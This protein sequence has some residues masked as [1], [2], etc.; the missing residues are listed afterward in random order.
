MTE[1]AISEAVLAH[2]EALALAAEQIVRWNFEVFDLDLGVTAAQDVRERS[3]ERHR[4]NVALDAISRV[5][6]FDEEGRELLVARRVRI[7]LGH[8]EGNIG[9]AC[10][11]RKPFLA[12]QD[13][14]VV[15]G[16]LGARLHARGVRAGR[17]L[18]HRIADALF[19]VQQWLQELF[20]LIFGAVLKQSKHGGVVG[21]LRVHR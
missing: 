1:P 11:A 12:V 21:P 2:A 19:A 7:G 17:F 5:R 20:L 6:Q 9:D 18:G 15:A 14:F 16:F 10:G 3:F 13:I 4:R 8:D